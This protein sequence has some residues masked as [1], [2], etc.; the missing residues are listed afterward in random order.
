MTRKEWEEHDRVNSVLKDWDGH[1]AQYAAM[2]DYEKAIAYKPARGARKPGLSQ[3]EGAGQD[4]R[5]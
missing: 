4:D 2:I 5:Y 3:I 1:V